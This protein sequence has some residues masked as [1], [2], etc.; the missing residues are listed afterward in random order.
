MTKRP[1]PLGQKII[2]PAVSKSAKVYGR[3]LTA[4][5]EHVHRRRNYNRQHLS[6]IFPP[7]EVM[8]LTNTE[9]CIFKVPQRGY[10]IVKVNL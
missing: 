6:E 7:L 9:P 4:V 3:R 10:C 5:I 2:L 8:A 1:V